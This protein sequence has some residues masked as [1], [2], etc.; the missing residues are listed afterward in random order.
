MPS[1]RP[2]LLLVPN[3]PYGLCRRKATLNSKFTE[4]RHSHTNTGIHKLSLSLSLSLSHTHTHTHMHTHTD[5]HTQKH[6]DTHTHTHTRHS[7]HFVAIQSEL[8]HRHDKDKQVR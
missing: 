3:S 8:T 7:L 6:T 5:K 4:L 1:G 2:G